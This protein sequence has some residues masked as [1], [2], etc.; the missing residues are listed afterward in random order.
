M[1]STAYFIGVFVSAVILVICYLYF[2]KLKNQ[3]YEKYIRYFMGIYLLVTVFEVNLFFYQNNLP[4][5]AYIP[6]GLCGISVLLAI[7]VLFTKSKTGF[8]ILFFWGWGAFLA[9]FAPNIN[10]GPNR[11]YFYQFYLRHLLIVIASMY[12]M[13][14]FDYKIFQ[15][16]Y[17]TYIYVTL[18]LALASLGLGY[19]INATEYSN[20][21]YIVKPVISGT[22][23]D[24]FYDVHP[25]FYTAIWILIAFIFGFLYGLPFYQK[26]YKKSEIA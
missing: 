5:Y 15:K 3:V 7:Y 1:F 8:I 13:R 18:P 20:Y 2:P 14:V 26:E 23:L 16:D 25:L 6:E 4:W 10:E 11:Y 17:R 9:L 12:M 21:L 22:P 24:L 19:M